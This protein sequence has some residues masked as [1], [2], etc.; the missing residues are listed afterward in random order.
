[1]EI[2]SWNVNGLRAIYNKGFIP[3]VKKARPDILCL[4]EI[5]ANP[6]QLPKK[7]TDFEEYHEFFNPA[8]RI[9]VCC[10]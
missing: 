6:E 5:K 10:P 1:M 3:W 8:E 4:Q 7:L 9:F 2:M